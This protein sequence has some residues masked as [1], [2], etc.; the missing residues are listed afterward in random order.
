MFI[1]V[2]LQNLF[3]IRLAAELNFEHVEQFDSIQS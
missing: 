2:E 3:M 1:I